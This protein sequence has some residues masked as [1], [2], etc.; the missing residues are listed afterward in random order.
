MRAPHKRF[1]IFLFAFAMPCVAFGAISEGLNNFTIFNKAGTSS[2]LSP[3]IQYAKP[4]WTT[5]YSMF[6]AIASTPLGSNL[7]TY[8]AKVNVGSAYGDRDAYLLRYDFIFAG[9][10]SLSLKWTHEDWKYISTSKDSFGFEYNSYVPILDKSG[11][12]GCIGGYYRYLKQKWN[13]PWWSPF[14]YN[15]KDQEYYFTGALGWKMALGEKSFYTFDLNIRDAWAYYGLDNVAFDLNFY[16]NGGPNFLW[17]LNA[18]TRSSAL[19]VGTLYPSIY[20]FGVGFV[21]Y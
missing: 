17:K 8:G 21:I 16:L 7:L 6:E 20:Y 3:Q 13:D 4:V 9:T 14:N 19:W 1:A 12:Y 10:S 15:T 5:A 18:G 11:V 2:S